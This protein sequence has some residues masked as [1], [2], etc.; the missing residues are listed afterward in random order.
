MDMQQNPSS[1]TSPLPQMG[2]PMSDE[3]EKSSGALIGTVIIIVVLILG[4]LYLWNNKMQ[5]EQI[6]RMLED[7]PM[8]EGGEMM[9]AADAD[10]ATAALSQQGTSDE[11]ADIE[12]DLNA[13]NFNEMDGE[14]QNL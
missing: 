13:T 7:G 12:A 9:P 3:D 5:E 4:G 2:A 14:L 10:A 8:I 1:N 6:D 11:T